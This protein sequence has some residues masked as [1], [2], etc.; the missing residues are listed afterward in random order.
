MVRVRLFFRVLRD[1]KLEDKVG[2]HE[3]IRLKGYVRFE[4]EKDWSEVY[5]TI[6][7][8]DGHT[9]V[10][11][12]SIWRGAKHTLLAEHGI[13]GIVAKPECRLPVKIGEI[14]CM[15]VDRDGNRTPPLPARSFLAETDDVPIILGFKDMLARLGVCFDYGAKEAYVEAKAGGGEL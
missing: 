6:V 13:Q 2:R 15:F 9:S 5:E 1:K 10:I 7:D 4:R 11:P 14:T 8:T 3:I 12:W